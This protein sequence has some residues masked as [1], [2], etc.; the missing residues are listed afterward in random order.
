M[1]ETFYGDW[2][3]EV[4]GW[5]LFDGV[6]ERFILEGSSSSNG[7]HPLLVETVLPPIAVSGNPWTIRF[8]ADGGSGWQPY[9]VARLSAEYTLKDGLVVYIGP[10]MPQ[11]WNLLSPWPKRLRCTNQT[12]SL[13]PWLPFTNPYSF[14]VDGPRPGVKPSIPI[15][16]RPVTKRTVKR[17]QDLT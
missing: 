7:A 10:R 12:P 6:H 15:K 16:R 8:E 9:E 11:S 2:T 5:A 1:A 3:L 4:D 14:T 13:N 17:G